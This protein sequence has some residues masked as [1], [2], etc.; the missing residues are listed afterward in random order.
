[1]RE[2]SVRAVCIGIVIGISLGAANAYVG[3]KVGM[4]VN[5]SIPAAVVAM[6]ILR[7]WLRNGSILECNLAQTIGSCGQSVAAGMIFTIPALFMLGQDPKLVEMVMWG[8]IGGLLG[9]CFMVPLRRLLIV[10]EHE[11]L[12]YPEGLACSKVLQSGERGGM[13]AAAVIRGA[14]VGGSFRLLS[15]LGFWPETSTSPVAPLIRTQASL[16][17]EPA[18]LGVGYI[19]G[20]RIAAV[21]FAGAATA[22]FVLIPAISF[23]GAGTAVN[24]GAWAGRLIESLSPGEIHSQY[25][26]YIG[27]GAVTAA[28]LISLIK[29]LPT[30]LASFWDVLKG[31]MQRNSAVRPRTD[32][33]L[34][35]G[36]LLTLLAGLA[37]TM[38]VFPQVRV[39]HVGAVAIIVFSFFFVTVTSRIVGLVGASSTPASG[40]TI[41]A[42]LATAL[43]FKHLAGDGAGDTMGMKVAC[44][45]VGAIVCS[46]ICISGDIA[47]DLKTGFLVQATPW[48]QQ[49]G[50]MIG[51]TSAVVANAAVIMLLA[52]AQGFVESA[53]HPN[54]LPAPQAN[55]MRIL[56]D[57]VFGGQLPW[58]LLIIGAALAVVVELL[59]VPA[60]PYAVGFY[61]PISLPAPIMVGGLLRLI[62][63]RRRDRSSESDPGIL[64]SSGLVAGNGLVGIGLVALTAG[65][66]WCAGDP[67][68]MN[69]LSGR[70]EPLAPHHLVPWLWETLGIPQRWG[71]APAAWSGWSLLPFALLT[72]WLWRQSRD[73]TAA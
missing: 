43:A 9:I 3:L 5:A 11:V 53:V 33:D 16:S 4:S 52:Q 35:S 22:T 61:L 46:A 51:V 54:P 26:R 27:A 58:E 49:T 8:G 25:I 39:G 65:I 23:F 56:V 30:I 2:F 20:P 47:Q 15:G 37:L 17:A 29:S 44:L 10:R 59:A 66:G 55:I 13:G 48:K 72:I 42:L 18:L 32:R 67:R 45:S 38:W 24:N 12:P 7:G 73:R 64:T 31:V 70:E 63:E 36:L 28:G 34:P 60:L 71:M 69:P 50:E 40:M 19:I 57:G 62:V 1:M 68:W 41:A 14:V 21:M 6:L